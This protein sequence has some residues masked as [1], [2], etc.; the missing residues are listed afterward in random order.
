MGYRRKPE[1]NAYK[2]MKTILYLLPV[3]ILLLSCNNNDDDLTRISD[4]EASNELD[5]VEFVQVQNDQVTFQFLPNPQTGNPELV[6][7][8]RF[9]TETEVTVTVDDLE[10]DLNFQHGN[11]NVDG[12]EIFIA[13]HS[14]DQMPLEPGDE[15]DYEVEIED[16]VYEGSIQLTD[17]L[18]A[19][20]PDTLK[21]DEP[22]N[23]SWEIES[24]PDQFYNLFFADTED[25]DLALLWELPGD[26][27]EGDFDIAE[28]FDEVSYPEKLIEPTLKLQAINFDNFVE[29][30]LIVAGLTSEESEY[31]YQSED[32]ESEFLVRE[33]LALPKH[34]STKITIQDQVRFW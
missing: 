23:Y 10:V 15:T 22:F 18:S 5:F 20:F 12:D 9:V 26:T 3:A 24:D 8:G 30:E 19:A 1:S 31:D 7:V 32:F 14:L 13:A 34:L 33:G 4:E 6:L 16:V 21:P 2:V 11:E 27:R 29:D 17:T 25:D 28:D